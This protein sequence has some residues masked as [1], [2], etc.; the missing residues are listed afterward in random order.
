LEQALQREIQTTAQITL[1]EVAY[2]G[3][4]VLQ[5]KVAVLA[6]HPS[7]IITTLATMVALVVAVL[8]QLLEV[9][10]FQE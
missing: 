7:P 5:Y 1:A 9:L 6:V 8:I 4:Q 3:Q 2:G 10:A